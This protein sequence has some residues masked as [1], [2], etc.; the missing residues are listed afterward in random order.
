[1]VESH[2]PF[3]L[4][5][6][7]AETHSPFPVSA[8]HLPTSHTKPAISSK[9]FLLP[10][11]LQDQ[12][13]LFFTDASPVQLSLLYPTTTT[14]KFPNMQCSTETQSSC[15][16]SSTCSHK[17][18][19]TTCSLAALHLSF[20]CCSSIFESLASF[21]VQLNCI[22]PVDCLL[23]STMFSL[24]IL[25]SRSIPQLYALHLYV[26]PPHALIMPRPPMIHPQWLSLPG[27]PKCTPPETLTAN[28]TKQRT[29]L[30]TFVTS[31]QPTPSCFLCSSW[32]RNWSFSRCEI[33][34]GSL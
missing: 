6:L 24:P 4:S 23:L 33:S 9:V 15:G 30:H 13:V 18:N 8:L 14:A 21:I 3:S 32:G 22:S 31:T 26:F 20:T 5:R 27:S 10:H 29:C 34:P 7:T 16:C 28:K 2:F 1:M 12:S 25:C 19:H 11:Q 17:P